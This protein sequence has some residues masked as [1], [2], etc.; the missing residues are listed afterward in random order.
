MIEYMG[1]TGVV[2][3]DPELS[4]FV[5]HVKDLGDEIY[6][7]GE[8]VE[9]L[10]MSLQRAVDHYLKVCEARGEEPERPYSGKLNLRL[11]PELH[12]AAAIAAATEGESLNSWLAKLV[13]SAA[14][15]TMVRE[16][17]CE[18]YGKPARR[19]KAAAT[20]AEGRKK[21]PE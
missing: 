8:S 13:E 2:E 5:G 9:A 7:E 14:G 10:K 18:S 21:R 1:Y 19:T 20:G 12:R 11:G 15:P 17:T 4:L 16:R 6:F 3:F